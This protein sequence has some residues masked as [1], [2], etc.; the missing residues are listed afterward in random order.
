ML[1]I[2]SILNKKGLALF[3]SKT[4]VVESSLAIMYDQGVS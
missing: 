3:H 4:F 2:E 1:G